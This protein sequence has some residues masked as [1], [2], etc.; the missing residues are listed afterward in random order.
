MLLM[1]EGS[2]A[3]TFDWVEERLVEAWG[4][5]R[6]MPDAEAGWMRDAKASSIYGRGRMT[7][8]ELWALYQIDSDDY[9]RDAVGRLPGLRTAEVD[10]MEE[11][12]GWIEHVEPRDR[13]LIGVVLA[14]LERGE[15]RPMWRAAAAKLGWGGHPDTLAKRYSRGIGRIAAMVSNAENG[16]FLRLDTVKQNSV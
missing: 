8:Q 9:D 2:A 11:A 16:G 12:L 1:K 7:R 10:R 5:M 15:A 6:R 3:V 13:K 4:F 14:Q